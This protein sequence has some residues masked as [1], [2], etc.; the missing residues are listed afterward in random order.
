MKTIAII[1]SCDTKYREICYMRELIEAQGVKALVIDVATGPDPSMGYDISR[2]EV[3]ESAGVS[4]QD[5]EP[6]SKGEKISF[7]TEAVAGYVEK[8]YQERKIDGIVSA[9]GLQNTVMATAAMQRLPIGVP[10]VMATTVA[11]GRKTFESIVA[12]KD[13][14]TIPSICDFTGL[15]LVTRQIIA[16]ACAACVGMVKNA[17]KPLE[18]GKKI[19]VGVTLMGITNVGA[20]AAVDELERLGIEAIGFHTTGV[21]GAIMEKMAEDGLING[22]LDLTTHEITQEYF[23]GGFSYGEDAKYRLVKGVQ[24]KVPLVISVGG[25]DFIDFCVGEFPERM[26]ERVYMMHNAN[27]AHI[28]LLPDEAEITTQRFVD[29]VNKIDYPVKLLIPTDGMR[30]NTRKGEEL[31]YHEVDEIILGKIKNITNPNV[32]I[33]TIPGNLDTKE[34]G[35]QAAHHMIDELK[36]RGV[37]GEEV[38]YK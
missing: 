15:N 32:E 38:S 16:N 24:K 4:W 19:V 26:D 23:K 37:I 35:I 21:G 12:D 28:K 34:W 13:I 2:E 22:I 17:G 5:M 14:V 27:T 33:I 6:K 10:K 11:S 18:K 7:M 30:H 31:Y 8:I 3:A 36:E 1:G 25:L 29:R 9:G 20:C